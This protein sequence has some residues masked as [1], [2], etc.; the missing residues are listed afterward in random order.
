[1]SPISITFGTPTNPKFQWFDSFKG[2]AD[3]ELNEMAVQCR[4][5]MA[6]IF[7][8]ISDRREP[9]KDQTLEDYYEMLLKNANR[10]NKRDLTDEHKGNLN[11]LYTYLADPSDAQTERKET[12]LARQYLWLVSRVTDWSYALLIL[13]ALGKHRVQKLDEDRRVKLIKHITQHR[14]SLFCPKLEDKAVH[15]NLHQI[16]KNISLY[17]IISIELS[18]ILKE[19][20]ATTPILTNSFQAAGAVLPLL[21]Q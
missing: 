15:C 13:G 18:Q 8:E 1:M 20:E 17:I 3:K 2:L 6:A 14:D 11:N 10:I 5:A 21:K 7:T 16:R 4:G 19:D 12:K 9:W